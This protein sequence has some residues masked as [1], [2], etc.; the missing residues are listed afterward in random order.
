[1]KNQWL[2]IRQLDQQLKDWQAV[3]R[4]HGNRPRIGWVKTIRSALSMSIEQLAQRLSLSTARVKQ[5]ERAEINDAV[6]LRTLRETANALECELIYAF[7]P[8]G[9]TSLEDI[10]KTRAKQIAKERV[11]RVARTMSLED[12]SINTKTI[13]VTIDEQTKDLLEHL[14]KKF[15]AESLEKY[16]IS[17]Q[18]KKKKK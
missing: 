10:L 3:T 1:M 6:T 13:A 4:K 17:T 11:T 18:K 7:V 16:I 14:N 2:M 5:L 9:N 12:Q 8:K 15:W